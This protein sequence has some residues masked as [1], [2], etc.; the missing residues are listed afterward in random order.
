[1]NIDHLT[2]HQIANVCTVLNSALEL[3]E[4][5]KEYF[6]HIIKLYIETDEFIKSI[7]ND[8]TKSI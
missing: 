7:K 8:K 4:E 2:T 5:E 1:M 3:S 6:Y